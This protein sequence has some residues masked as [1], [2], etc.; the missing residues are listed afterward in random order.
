MDIV[1]KLSR[2][3][4]GDRFSTGTDDLAVAAGDESTL[5]RVT[6]RAVVWALSIEEIQTIV[7]VCI[8]T[9]T[10]LTT[11]GAGSAL[12]GS[13]IP[14]ENGIVLDLS[15]MTS[16]VKLWPD[17][18]QVRV[19]PGLVYDDLNT[20]L[21]DEGL[22]FPPAPGGSGDIATIGGMVSTNASGIYSVKYGGTRDYVLALDMVTGTGEIVTLGN[23]AVKRSSGYDLVS[24]VVGSEGTLGVIAGITLRL[25]GL[26]EGRRQSAFCF[27]DD[28]RAARAVSEMARYGLDLA[29]VEFLDRALVQALNALKDYGLEESPCLFLEFHG[30]E[31]AIAATAELAASICEERGGRTLLLADGQ[32]PWEI[33]H[34][35]T[36][37]VKHRQ[38]GCTI[39]RNDVAFPISKLPEM[40]AFCHELG[41]KY[42]LTTHTFG[43]VG[44]GLL[45]ALILAHRE[46]P[47]EWKNAHNMSDEII[48]RTLQLGGT[49]SGEHGIGLGHKNLFCDEHGTSVDLMRGIKKAFD[50]HNIMNPGKV[51]DPEP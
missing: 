38:P 27:D 50:P 32:N 46:D 11:R 51:F 2:L 3:L 37:A 20:R 35:A 33:R 19:E 10:P 23:R 9:G 12:E 41:R 18:L 7:R 29:A 45:H 42:G 40:V 26:P 8:D 25:A 47:T 13:T 21:K 30:P 39:V 14:L 16:I 24:L 43:H 31:S 34:F 49:I 22:F 1:E 6:P 44:L 28:L 48:R 4:P 5:D 36:E 15:R 17:D